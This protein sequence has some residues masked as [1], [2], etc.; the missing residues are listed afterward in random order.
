M[1][2]HKHK[3]HLLSLTSNNEMEEVSKRIGW[4]EE[5][6]GRKAGEK[7]MAD[8]SSRRE[9]GEREREKNLCEL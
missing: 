7:R 1:G 8:S 6:L 4:S 2:K 5:W 9:A 3:K